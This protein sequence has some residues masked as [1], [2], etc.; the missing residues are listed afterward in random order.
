MPQGVG[1]R[2][3]PSPPT[4]C[5]NRNYSGRKMLTELTKLIPEALLHESAEAFYSG[6]RAFSELS[7]LY[8][9]GANPGAAST[10]AGRYR[11]QE[12]SDIVQALVKYLKSGIL[13]ILD[14]DLGSCNLGSSLCYSRIRLRRHIR[15]Q[16]SRSF[17][18]LTH[19]IPRLLIS[20]NPA[21]R[22]ARRA[23]PW[24]RRVIS[25]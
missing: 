16:P 25:V 10:Y 4:N 3:S 12:C 7:D 22:R 19:R 6:R 14:L 21:E 5:E 8:I 15:N 9:L 20:G 17:L 24:Y 1:V 18:K 13:I 2:I 11:I 23:Q